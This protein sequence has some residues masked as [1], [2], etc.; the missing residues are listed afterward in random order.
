MQ[1][2]QVNKTF[3]I[4]APDPVRVSG[5]AAPGPLT[6]QIDPQY[7][8]RRNLLSDL[9]GWHRGIQSGSIHDGLWLTGPMGSGKSS[10]IV[11]TAARLNL[12]LVE[13]NGKRRLEIAD[14]VGHL[15]AVGSDVLFQDGPLTTAVR[16]GAWFLINE[17]DLIDPGELAGL[18]T[19]LD[20]GPLIL[21]ENGG[22]VVFPA[23]GFGLIGTANTVGLGDGSGL[24]AGVQR[25]NAAFLDRFWVVQV[26][27]LTGEE[28]FVLV[29]R[30]VPQIRDELLRGMIQVAAEVRALFQGE[31][32]S[33]APL[34]MTFSSRT[35]IRW[36][37]L[38]VQY[39]GDKNPLMRTL[40]RAL[41]NR[42]E[43]EAAEAIEG[44]ARRIF[45]VSSPATGEDAPNA[46]GTMAARRRSVL[47]GFSPRVSRI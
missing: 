30:R 34:D 28:E 10:L 9:L 19:L 36:A 24:Y 1:E 18:N 23:P 15:T 5:F 38:T 16:H 39:A 46:A 14:W 41:T 29:K 8:F 42:V 44:M 6:P 47:T 12:N 17:A 45:G 40:Q 35:L 3:G 11:Q 4:A 37:Y 21:P 25:L 33:T 22:E 13:V 20:G 26:D 7:T 27:Y 32:E 43:P 31:G 2:F